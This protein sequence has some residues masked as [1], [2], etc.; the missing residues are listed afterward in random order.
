MIV[1]LMTDGYSDAA[2]FPFL[3]EKMKEVEL[4]PY[5]PMKESTGFISSRI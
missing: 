4:H 2:I 3:V 5:V 1:E